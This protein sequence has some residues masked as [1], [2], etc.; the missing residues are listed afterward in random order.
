MRP[1]VFPY[2]SYKGI[3][4]PIIPI[5]TKGKLGWARIW[6][7]VDSGASY[8]LFGV[9]EAERLGIEFKRGREGKITVGDGSM[10]PFYLHSLKARIGNYEI[11]AQIGFSEKLGVGFNLLGRAEIFNKFDVTFSDSRKVIIFKKV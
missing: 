8:S 7:Y 6:V 4:A 9:E 11:T 3:A 10:I 5:E 2:S 1:V